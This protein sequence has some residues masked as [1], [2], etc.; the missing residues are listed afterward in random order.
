[1]HLPPLIPEP[2]VIQKIVPTS[3]REVPAEVGRILSKVFLEIK[4]SRARG[5]RQYSRGRLNRGANTNPLAFEAAMAPV[6]KASPTRTIVSALGG[7]TRLRAAHSKV[8]GGHVRGSLSRTAI[9]MISLPRALDHW[10]PNTVD[11]V[12][13]GP[14]WAILSLG[15]PLGG[16]L[17]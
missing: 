17:L 9:W 8:G 13:I 3:N 4:R 12:A 10:T 16:V 15:N 11:P 1:M 6:D 2:S 7:C 14:L 5:G